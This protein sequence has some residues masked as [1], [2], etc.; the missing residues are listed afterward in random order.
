MKKYDIYCGFLWLIIAAFVVIKA[1]QIGLG[2]LQYPG[3]GFFPLIV[4]IF[5]VSLS[6]ILLLKIVKEKIKLIN[7]DNW[8]SFSIKIFITWGILIIYTIFLDMLGFIFCSLIVLFY[9]FKMPAHKSFLFSIL[10]S[11][12]TVFASY[13]FFGVLLQAQLP[14]G[15]G[16]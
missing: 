7:F 5:L 10:V 11:I 6:S 8:P 12:I 9:L 1:F 14:K 4:G 13:Y 15:F 16:R 2:S 3:P